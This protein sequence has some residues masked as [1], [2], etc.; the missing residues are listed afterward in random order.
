MVALSQILQNS[1]ILRRDTVVLRMACHSASKL[2]EINVTVLKVEMTI[3]RRAILLQS[4]KL[5]A[6]LYFLA[7]QYARFDSHDLYKTHKNKCAEICIALIIQISKTF[8]LNRSKTV[9]FRFYTSHS[10]NRRGGEET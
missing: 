5:P 10:R 7:P 4:A 9:L 3:P 2:S 6:G 1:V 8:F